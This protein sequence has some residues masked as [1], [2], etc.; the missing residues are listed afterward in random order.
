MTLAI[1]LGC[2]AGVVWFLVRGIRKQKA[3]GRIQPGGNA[4]G[5]FLGNQRADGIAEKNA[6][7]ARKAEKDQPPTE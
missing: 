6:R 5:Q 3:A 2:V 7:D 4:M 1:C